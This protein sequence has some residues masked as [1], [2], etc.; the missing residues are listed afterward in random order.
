MSSSTTLSGCQA[1]AFVEERHLAS[2]LM[3]LQDFAP[4]ITESYFRHTVLENPDLQTFGGRIPPGVVVEELSSGVVHGFSA[5]FPMEYFLKQERICVTALGMTYVAP[6]YRDYT[7]DKYIYILDYPGIDIL[8]SNTVNFRSS[9]LGK[10]MRFTFGP[11]SCGC[12][13]Y[14]F[15]GFA[16]FAVSM[17]RGHF[18]SLNSFP[19]FLLRL[20]FRPIDMVYHRLSSRGGNQSHTEMSLTS[21]IDTIRIGDFHKKLV[22]ANQG[23]LR[24][25]R[26]E[27][28][29]WVF[30]EKLRSGKCIMLCRHDFNGW[31]VGYIL[32]HKGAGKSSGRLIILDWIALGNQ[33]D[34]LADLLHDAKNYAAANGFGMLMTLGYPEWIQPTIRQILPHCRPLPN[35]HFYYKIQNSARR[36]EFQVYLDQSW[37]FGMY[38]GDASL[39]LLD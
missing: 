5:F 22:E 14:A 35:N 19:E 8:I 23:I 26:P 24:S 9:Q 33:V 3:L 21:E 13:S 25:R 20:P 1:C 34:V 18:P 15:T 28:L 17:V 31:V 27:L 12:Q 30:G 39:A 7:T 4:G 6:A 29:Q 36:H 38:D 2:L 11:E 37:L 16:G 32:L 10:A